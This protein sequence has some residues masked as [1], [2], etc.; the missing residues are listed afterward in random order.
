MD[1]TTIVD[2]MSQNEKLKV[3]D[4]YQTLENSGVIVPEFKDILNKISESDQVMWATALTFAVTRYFTNLY[5]Q[6]TNQRCIGRDLI[7]AKIKHASQEF[8]KLGE[9]PSITS[10]ENFLV[11]IDNYYDNNIAPSPSIRVRNEDRMGL[12]FGDLA[13]TWKT[14]QLSV[15]VIFEKTSSSEVLCILQNGCGSKEM[16]VCSFSKLASM[17]ESMVKLA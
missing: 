7:L 10:I 6:E 4:Y 1:L 3:L 11:F 8:E 12:G 16:R 5:I 9:K 15:E 17:L 13:V 2:N 14:K